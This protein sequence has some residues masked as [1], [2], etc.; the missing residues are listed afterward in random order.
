MPCLPLTDYVE[1]FQCDNNQGWIEIES[2]LVYRFLNTYSFP[3]CQNLTSED[4][5]TC[6]YEDFSCVK[7]YDNL[8]ASL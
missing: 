7:Y 3:F 4:M 5:E 1:R 2:L 8:S 6:N